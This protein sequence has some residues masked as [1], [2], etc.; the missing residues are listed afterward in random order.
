MRKVHVFGRNVLASRGPREVSGSSR[1][2]HVCVPFTTSV[3]TRAALNAAAALTRNLGARLTL[4]SVLIVP[5]PLPLE[6][7]AVSLN[8]VE[9]E[10]QVVARDVELELDARVVIARDRPSAF[11]RAVSPG[12]LVVLATKKRWW[13]TR[14]L[15][16]ARLLARA[17][18]SV[19]L[20]EI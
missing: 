6:R 10:L 8:F 5:F 9:H 20:L 1:A 7:P 2:L 19:A 12:S 4:M 11:L 16:L 18:H 14:Q 15:K 17:G 13:P 3:L